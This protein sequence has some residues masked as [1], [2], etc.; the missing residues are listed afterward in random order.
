[1]LEGHR[2]DPEAAWSCLGAFSAWH[3]GDPAAAD[4]DQRASW[5]LDCTGRM[6]YIYVFR[7]TPILVQIFI[8]YYGFPQFEFHPREH[9]LA[10]SCASRLRL[11]DRGP[12]A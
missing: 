9:F 2:R 10:L 5:Y 7:G 1:M 8:V 6:V 3:S 4:A 11:R 12:D